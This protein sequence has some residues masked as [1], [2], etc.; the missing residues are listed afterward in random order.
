MLMGGDK[1]K[2]KEGKLETIWLVERDTGAAE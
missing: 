2:E 1:R